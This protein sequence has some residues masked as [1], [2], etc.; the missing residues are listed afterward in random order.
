MK[1]FSEYQHLEG[2]PMTSRDKKEANSKFWG[3]GK[4]DNFILPLLPK[5]C[6]DMTFVD[7][8]CN[9]GL[10]LGLAD[11]KGFRR[12]IGVDSNWEAIER[13]LKYRKKI[14][15][16]SDLKL[17]NYELRFGEIQDVDLPLADYVVF[18]NSHYY[19]NIS[20]FTFLLDRLRNR[21]RYCLIVSGD[22]Q[23]YPHI[24][25]SKA[26]DIRNYFE[27]WKEVDGIGEISREGDSS[28]RKLW[29]LAFQSPSL[30]RVSM[31]GLD[32]GN[33]VQSSFYQQLDAGVDYKKTKYYK[34][35]RGYRLKKNP[36]SLSVWTEDQL[37][38]FFE[39]KIS[40]YKSIKEDGLENPIIVNSVGKILDGNHRY[41]I[42]KHLGHRTILIR[43]V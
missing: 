28:P 8:G 41:M 10:F 7:M 27:D 17:G 19:L 1:K 24:A 36:E 14:I 29:T 30:K 9:A 38:I 32:C 39:G 22:K 23:T 43:E 11:K 25:S 26:K 35:I 31:K 37:H 12:S 33:Y 15:S 2:E 21:T 42:L 3:K 16:S 18:V 4:W 5:R 13:G 6:E 40:L 20:D 34:I